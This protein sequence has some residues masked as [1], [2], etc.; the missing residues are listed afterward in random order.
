MWLYIAIIVYNHLY[1]YIR[2]HLYI[3][4]YIRCISSTHEQRGCNPFCKQDGAPCQLSAVS[5]SI[6]A[7]CETPIQD[8]C[9]WAQ[10]LSSCFVAHPRNG[11]WG[12][13]PSHR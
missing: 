8:S 12:V 7:S 6:V 11:K 5:G 10:S 9:C 4:I 13:A 2:P 1:L 3:Y